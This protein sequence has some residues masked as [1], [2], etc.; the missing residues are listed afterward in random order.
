M[1]ERSV[2]LVEQVKNYLLDRI[3]E[4]GYSESG[5]R[6]PS[7]NQLSAELNVS[8][9]TVREALSQLAR[10]GTVIRRHGIGTFVNQHARHLVSSINEVVEFHEM[11]TN[12]GYDADVHLAR[13]E[14]QPAGTWAAEL[15]LE[16]DDDVVLVDKVF[17]AGGNPVIF[18]RNTVSLALFPKESRQGLTSDPA[19][20][21]PIYK[22]L[23]ER[24]REDVTHHVARIRAATAD[25]LIAETLA[26]PSGHPLLFISEV[27]YNVDQ[28]P[29]VSCLEYYRDDLIHFHAVRG[30]VRPFSWESA[31]NKS[32]Y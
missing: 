24:C 9:S 30:L 28:N 18:C 13:V 4:G 12:Q 26:C 5:G 7:E 25:R 32:E 10:Q 27:G 15:G 11:I 3:V 31:Q 29:V 17:L 14:I 6:L 16:P 1:I 8:R 2:P 22:I 19:W 23:L 21:E 20:R